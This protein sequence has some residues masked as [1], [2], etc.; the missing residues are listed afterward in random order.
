MLLPLSFHPKFFKPYEDVSTKVISPSGK[1]FTNCTLIC[2]VDLL[3]TN[4]VFEDFNISR[5]A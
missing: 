1:A 4:L 5:L 2:F 3:M